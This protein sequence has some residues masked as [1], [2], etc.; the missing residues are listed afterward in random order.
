MSATGSVSSTSGSTGTLEVPIIDVMATVE[1]K[2]LL[3][4]GRL[5]GKLLAD[6]IAMR[7]AGLIPAA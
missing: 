3:E 5:A 6:D 2:A 7:G 4:S 1:A